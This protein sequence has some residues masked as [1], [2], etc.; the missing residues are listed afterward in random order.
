MFII[1]FFQ[2]ACMCAFGQ[3]TDSILKKKFVNDAE[4]KVWTEYKHILKQ[5]IR[6]DGYAH[7]DKNFDWMQ[8]NRIP[9][10]PIPSTA[11]AF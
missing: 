9:S 2:N 6:Y 4:R 8:F 5:Q 10:H 1:I 7:N 11:I 3:D